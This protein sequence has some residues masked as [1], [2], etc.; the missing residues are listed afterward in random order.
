[1]IVLLQAVHRLFVGRE[2]IIAISDD[3]VVVL[4][5]VLKDLE[6]LLLTGLIRE[7]RL[8]V[9]VLLVVGA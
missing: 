4:N 3:V 9:G 6:A 1:M 5:L 8:I 7:E 2:T